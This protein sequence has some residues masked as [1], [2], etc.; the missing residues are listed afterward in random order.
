[1]HAFD[2]PVAAGTLGQAIDVGF[3]GTD[4]VACVEGG[5]VGVL[6]AGLDLEERLDVGEAGLAR[7]LRSDA[8]QS[9]VPE[10]VYVRVSM[11]PWPFSTVVLVTSSSAGAV[12]K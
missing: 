7:M 5:A 12:R 1:M 6:G 2:P 11:R 10:A 4:E 9:T 8:I 3:C